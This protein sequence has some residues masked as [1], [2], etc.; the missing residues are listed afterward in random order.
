M[1]ETQNTTEILQNIAFYDR[2]YPNAVIFSIQVTVFLLL[3]VKIKHT[4]F[5]FW[6][7]KKKKK[8]DRGY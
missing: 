1:E 8:K 4:V 7:S 5:D 3:N 6:M 2:K